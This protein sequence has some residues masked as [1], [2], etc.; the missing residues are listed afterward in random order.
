MANE[1]INIVIAARDAASGVLT[2][3]GHGV[4]GLGNSLFSL[5]GLML[6]G[7]GGYGITEILRGS[8]VAWGEQ[9]QASAKLAGVLRATGGAAGFSATQLEDHASALQKTTVYADEAII[10]AQAILAT[11]KEV[12]GDTFSQAT[13]AI[14]DLSAVMGVDLSA[15]AK[16]VGK[17]LQDP[18]RGLTALRKAGVS[19]SEQDQKIIKGLAETGRLAEA[20]RMILAEL[21][22]EFGGVA[23]AM[24]NTATGNM[25]KFKNQLGEIGERIGRAVIPIMVALAD[26]VSKSF[27]YISDSFEAGGNNIST[28]CAYIKTALDGWITHMGLVGTYAVVMADTTIREF[29]RMHR[30]AVQETATFMAKLWLAITSKNVHEFDEGVKIIDQSRKETEKG[31]SA[32]ELA[33]LA[34][35]EKALQESKADFALNLPKNLDLFKFKFEMP[36]LDMPPDVQNTIDAHTKALRNEPMSSRFLTMLPGTML[37]AVQDKGEK[38]LTEIKTESQKHNKL[39]EQ[40]IQVTKVQLGQKPLIPVWTGG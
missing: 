11:F 38:R 16:M 37:G 15:A 20:Q 19:F 21:K 35:F 36:M 2:K 7:L 3:V 13:E 17:A 8:L 4:R 34:T 6:A 30:G 40:L 24:G 33:N 32:S 28:A 29:T 26:A 10:N 5:K 27:S 9:E 18:E 23:E 39:L 25:L 14:L 1:A 31:L 12:K 22:S